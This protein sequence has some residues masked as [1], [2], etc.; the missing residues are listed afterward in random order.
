MENSRRMLQSETSFEVSGSAGQNHPFAYHEQHYSTLKQRKIQENHHRKVEKNERQQADNFLDIELQNF[1]ETI[2]TQ[3][4]LDAFVSIN[5]PNN[6]EAK[7]IANE[8]FS[9]QNQFGVEIK[10]QELLEKIQFQ[11]LNGENLS[12]A[13]QIKTDIAE[14]E[15]KGK[16]RS[17][18]LQ[19]LIVKLGNEPAVSIWV[20]NWRNFLALHKIAATKTP[21]E[22][23]AIERILS[24]ADLTSDNAFDVSLS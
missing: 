15:E 9:R 22:Q 20:E 11:L 7:K 21:T 13:T 19:I 14:F 2:L 5:F 4:E 10:K 23:K 12:V 3:G 8:F 1:E 18:I 16:S 17:E 24:Q 6:F